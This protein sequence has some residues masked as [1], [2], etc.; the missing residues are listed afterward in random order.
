M[1]SL[2]VQFAME[3]LRT[4]LFSGINPV[5]TSIG[6]PLNE[7]IRIFAVQNLTDVIIAF[8]LDGLNDNFVL[9]ANGYRIVDVSANDALGQGWYIP[10]GTRFYAR[11]FGSPTTTGAVYVDVAYGNNV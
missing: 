6:T 2:S 11:T 3:P 1:S 4:L 7:G 10:M 9:P 8:S 5:Y